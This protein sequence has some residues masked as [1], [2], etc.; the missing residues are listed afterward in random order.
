M[1]TTTNQPGQIPASDTGTNTKT[2]SVVGG[3][4]QLTETI[5]LKKLTPNGID[6]SAV[7]VN[8]KQISHVPPT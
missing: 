2:V 1:P 8:G 4:K 5:V 3:A 6:G 7:F